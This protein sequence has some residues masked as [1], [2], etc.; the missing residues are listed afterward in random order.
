MNVNT[1]NAFFGV[2]EFCKKKK[3]KSVMIATFKDKESI[4]L[5]N[6]VYCI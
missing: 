3:K 1:Y 5:F 4:L 6:K 2:S